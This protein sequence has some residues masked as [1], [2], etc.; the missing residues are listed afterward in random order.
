[1]NKTKN[2][3]AWKKLFE[4]YDLLNEID[5]NGFTM[6]SSQAINTV[7]ESRLMTKFDC[8]AQS[9]AIFKQHNLGILPITRGSYLIGRFNIFSPIK[10]E[11]S[12]IESI[13]NPNSLESISID[14]I[15]SEASAINFAYVSGI[16]SNF[17]EDGQILPTVSGRMSS[18]S[19]S[20]NVKSSVEDLQS[21]AV[22]VSAAQIEIDGGYEGEECLA[23][24]EA[25][26]YISDDFLIRQLY[27]PYRLWN[28]KISKKVRPIFLT[29]SN[30]IF[31]IKEYAFEFEEEYNSVKMIKQ[32]RYMVGENSLNT[33]DLSNILQASYIVEEPKI[34]FPQADSFDRVINFC[35][36]LFS[37]ESSFSKEEILEEYDFVPRQA[38]YYANAAIYLGLVS[39]DAGQYILTRE[40]VRIFSMPILN[41]QKELIK[42][43]VE[44]KAFRK[45]LIAYL[46]SGNKPN[47]SQIIQIMKESDLYNIGSDSTFERRASTI[48]SWI[49]W[50]VS[51]VVE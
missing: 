9:P 33:E 44:H 14:D 50:I 45:T 5:T 51:R 41:R 12:K 26:N 25:K 1:M 6:I 48:S 15:S 36:L 49:E 30:G 7:R 28:R 24:I 13:V 47:K 34:P 3:H 32:K 16:F 2:D 27:Y 38:N 43:I 17:L 4:T 10:D 21:Y 29:Y 42:L 35:E 40:G 22:D 8:S 11:V 20:F 31:D 19:F 23:L 46:S 37:K 18:K 39:R